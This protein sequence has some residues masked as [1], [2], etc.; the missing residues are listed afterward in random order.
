MNDNGGSKTAKDFSFTVNG[1]DAQ[2]FDGDELTST[3]TVAVE[4][5]GQSVTIEESYAHGYTA[6]YSYCEDIKVVAGGT[7]DCYITNDDI[8]PEIRVHKTTN[9]CYSYENFA[10]TMTVDGQTYD[11]FE[12]T[13][14]CYKKGY[15]STDDDIKIGEVTISEESTD[16]WVLDDA[17]CY[18][19]NNELY[20][21]GTTFTIEL[22]GDYDC[23][24]YNTQLSTVIV[25]K[26][27][28]FDED[29]EWMKVNR[30]SP[31]GK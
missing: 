23:Y 22:G 19:N 15:Y 9:P 31:T 14:G 6:S 1:G 20:T 13:G 21:T 5:N 4:E 8:A 10:F 2:Y 7:Y 30:S 27:H 16:G 11:E 3:V 17:Y 26:F 24:F 29:G 28:D 18:D 25:T 12:L